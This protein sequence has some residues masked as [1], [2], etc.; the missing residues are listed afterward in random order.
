MDKM[1]S[2]AAVSLPLLLMPPEKLPGL[3]ETSMAALLTEIAPVLVMPP[4]GP[5]VPKRRPS[6]Q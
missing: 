5:P 4:P 6:T 2:P 3:E 1:P